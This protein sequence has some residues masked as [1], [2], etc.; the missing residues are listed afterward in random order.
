MARERATVYLDPQVLKAA[1]VMAART[2]RKDS[3]LV[4]EALRKFL[5]FGVLEEIWASSDSELSGDEALAL[6]DEE[7][8]AHRAER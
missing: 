5:G 3:E 6:A 7:L 2:G 4:E 8:H 1:R